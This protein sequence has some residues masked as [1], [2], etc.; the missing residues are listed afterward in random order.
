[1]VWD[2]IRLYMCLFWGVGAGRMFSG[3]GWDRCLSIS[4]HTFCL[5][6]HHL[7]CN[8]SMLRLVNMVVTYPGCLER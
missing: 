1:M 3:E 7:Y 2:V 5:W 8:V 6:Y 4:V